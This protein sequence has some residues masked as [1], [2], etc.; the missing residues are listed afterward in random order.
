MKFLLCLTAIFLTLIGFAQDEILKMSGHTIVGEIV[1]ITDF[2]VICQ[3]TKK[4]G[5]TKQ[6]AFQR[7]DVF[8]VTKEGQEE[9]IFYQQD[10]FIG[11][12]YTVQEMRIY[13]A[14]EQDALNG[15]D[16][17]PTK[18]VGVLVGAGAG[19]AS[20]GGLLLP[21]GIPVT[22][23]LLQLA[24]TIKIREETISNIDHKYNDIYAAG[25]ESV[26]RSKKV[27]AGL[28]GSALGAFI[29]VIFYFLI[30]E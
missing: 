24:P 12:D 19:V 5:K 30:P 6:V 26:A 13:I 9:E 20:Q 8:S 16:P 27:L 3:I 23:T 22:Y 2:Q 17:S 1:E 10:S 11:D 21:I 15:Y 25:Y 4:N 29:G 7:S 14:G 18:Y 28:K